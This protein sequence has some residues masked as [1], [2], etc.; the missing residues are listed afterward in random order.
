MGNTSSL[1]VNYVPSGSPAALT[2]TIE[3]I[4]NASGDV[5]VLDS[6]SGTTNTTRTVSLGGVSYDSFRFTASWTGGNNVSVGGSVA[7]TGAGPQFN[8]NSLT[9]FQTYTAS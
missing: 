6:Y 4:V 2:V 5:A 7:S 3:G 8:S 1:T 9:A